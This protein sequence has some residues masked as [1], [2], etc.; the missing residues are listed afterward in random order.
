MAELTEEQIERQDCV[1]GAI[2]ELLTKVN[3][4]DQEIEWNIELIAD[5]RDR[6]RYWFIEYLNLTDEMTFYPYIKE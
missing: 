4:S 2:Y 1:D 3:P 6:I 5:L